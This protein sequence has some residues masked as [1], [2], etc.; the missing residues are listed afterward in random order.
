MRSHVRFAFFNSSGL[1]SGWK[2]LIFLILAVFLLDGI[3][4]LLHYLAPHLPTRDHPLNVIVQELL[5][6]AGVV[7]LTFL[8]ARS[9]RRSLAHYGLPAREVLGRNFWIGTVWGFTTVSILISLLF[10]LGVY[11]GGRIAIGGWSAL[12]YAGLWMIAF[13]LVGV[14]EE[15]AF[16]GVLLFSLKGG[17]GFWAAAVIDSAVFALAHRGNPGETWI[18]L[19]GVFFVAMF[20]CLTIYKTGSLWFAIG[21]HMTF[22]WGESFLYS[23]PDSGTQAVGHLLNSSLHGSPWLTGGT[24]GPEGSIILLMLEIVMFLMF[25]LVYSSGETRSSRLASDV[26][27]TSD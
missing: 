12:K 22:D 15:V 6:A 16:R 25:W 23:V 20:L 24:A 2:C 7:L 10:A 26:V 5:Q 21:F 1:R 4:F 9:G 18:G 13:L 17:V 11:S 3:D 14:F 8:M 27:P 19:V